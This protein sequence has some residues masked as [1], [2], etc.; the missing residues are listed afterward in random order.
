[1]IR[2]KLLRRLAISVISLAVI[3]EF[4]VF[5]HW[6]SLVWWFDMPMHFLGGLSVCY[7][8]AMVWLNCFEGKT[9]ARIFWNKNVLGFPFRAKLS[10][11]RFLFD[12]VLTT[13][14]I[15]VLWEGLEFYL[16]MQYGNPPFIMLDSFSDIFFDIAGALFAV[17]GILPLL[18]EE[19]TARTRD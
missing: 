2:L 1:M 9:V 19:G 16:F 4:A 17:Y 5:L 3:N 8:S 12:A 18:F 7:F 10:N 14:L 11:A 6:Y 15:G 13:L